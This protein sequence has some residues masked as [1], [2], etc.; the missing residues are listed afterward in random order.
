MCGIA[1]IVSTSGAPVDRRHLAAM[2]ATMVHRGPDAEGAW[3]D[4]RGVVGFAHRRLSII[5]LGGSAQPMATPDGRHTIC[6]NG[7]ILNYRQL[8]SGLAH[9]FRTDGDT[10]VLLALH[11]RLGTEAPIRLRGQFAYA[12]HDATTGSVDLVRDR[13]GILPLFWYQ[14]AD[15]VLFASEAKAIVAVLRATDPAAVAVDVD[16]LDAYLSGVAVPA[17]HTLFA[18]IRKVRPGHALRV[19]ADGTVT[20]R[21][22]WSPPAELDEPVSPAAAVAGLRDRLE[23][24]VDAALVADVP[25]GAYLSGGLDSSLIAALVAAR[26]HEPV[27]TFSAGFARRTD[28]PAPDDELPFAR[29]VS[30]LLGTNHHEV[31]VRPEDFESAWSDL[32]WFR[33]APVSQ[34]ADVAVARLAALARQHVKVVLS[35]EGS[36]ELFAG[37]PK[38]G[39][40]RIARLADAVP[41]GLRG[42]VAA[43]VEARL[44]GRI[45]AGQRERLGIALRA[46]GAADR[47]ERHRQWFAPFTAAERRALLGGSPGRAWQREA[48]ESADGDEIRRMLLL[49]SQGWLADN[50]LERG[51]R[52]S[53]SASLELR[54]PFLDADLVDYA[55]RL[56]SSLKVRNGTRKWIVKEV[57]RRH[58]PADIV[59]RRK[60]GFAV[61]LE[62]W[63][64]GPLRELARDRLASAD[65]FAC[66]VFDRGE[67]VALLDRHERGVRD[68]KSR[69]W[70]LLSLEVWHDRH[71][72]A[73]ADV[74]LRDL[75]A[76]PDTA[77]SDPADAPASGDRR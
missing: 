3:V 72:G 77:P 10:E 76:T 65:S 36:D 16:S 9:D 73:G 22:W 11:A 46:L 56:P 15:R 23:A 39:A 66:Q 40:A 6:F 4:D 49:D 71:L 57:A 63:F 52:M 31:V 47:G 59:D 19:H 30:A 1:G 18:G 58:L 53:M 27:E 54:P 33:D 69:I 29:R 17:P 44:P 2:G 34:P 26:H 70:T 50:L 68:E 25:V 35:G 67:V 45:P 55:F 74:D 60:V 41:A 13:M 48:I 12:V 61:P 37:Y 5:D 75:P 20:E 64:R 51:D 42:R 62:D 21:R 32:T 14:D 8:R 43:A 24:A 28:G 7:E 38:Y